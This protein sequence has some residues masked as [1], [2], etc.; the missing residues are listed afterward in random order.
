MGC[1]SSVRLMRFQISTESST[2]F[3]VTGMLQWSVI[4]QHPHRPL[5]QIVHLHQSQ[6]A[7]FHS[8]RLGNLWDWPQRLRKHARVWRALLHHA[9]LHD[10]QIVILENDASPPCPAKSTIRSARSPG[11]IDNE[12]QRHGRRQQPLIATDLLEFQTARPF[13][14]KCQMKEPAIRPIEHAET[15][16]ARLHFQ[17]RVESCR[18]PG[19]RRQTLPAPKPTSHRLIPDS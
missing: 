1:E 13:C 2:G 4:Q 19:R 17:I 7:S 6:H 8:G 12:S 18:S 3:S 15:I 5:H 14:R 16:L 10:V 9:K 11:A